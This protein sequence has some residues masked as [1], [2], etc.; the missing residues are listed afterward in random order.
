MAKQHGEDILMTVRLV[1][2]PTRTKVQK[3]AGVG[4]RGASADCALLVPSRGEKVRRRAD[5]ERE[6]WHRE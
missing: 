4:G 3:R 1:T 2:Y 6:W 5:A